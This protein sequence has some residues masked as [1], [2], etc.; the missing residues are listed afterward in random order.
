LT[1]TDVLFAVEVTTRLTM[2]IFAGNERGLRV[3]DFAASLTQT[4]A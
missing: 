1:N 3:N 2:K 4:M